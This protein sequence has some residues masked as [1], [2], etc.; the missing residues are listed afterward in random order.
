MCACRGPRPPQADLRE[1]VPES[2]PAAG[3]IREVPSPRRDSQPEFDMQMA[4]SITVAVA[5]GPL[6]APPLQPLGSALRQPA[7]IL[8]NY[9]LAPTSLSC[10]Q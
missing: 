1:S 9:Q 10:P 2:R 6:L 4:G 7:S 8:L 3:E 5:R